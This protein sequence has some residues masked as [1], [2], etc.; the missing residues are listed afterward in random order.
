MKV[1]TQHG[2]QSVT[3][4]ERRG[5]WAI[6]RTIMR[7]NWTKP[8]GFTVSLESTGRAIAYG[9]TRD[10]ARALASEVQGLCPDGDWER[11][12]SKLLDA[13]EQVW[14]RADG[15]ERAGP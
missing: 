5:P 6:H 15:T 11:V 13:R 10:A 2:E 9:L 8:D 3:V 7:G 14:P 4:L 1:Q 12:A